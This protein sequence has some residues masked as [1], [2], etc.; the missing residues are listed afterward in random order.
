M[1]VRN[2]A[3]VIARCLESVRP[4]VGHWV[5]VDTGSTDATRELVRDLMVDVPG[6]LLRHEWIDFGHNRSLALAAARPHAE[7]TLMIDADEIFDVPDGF[8]WP[9]LTSDSVQLRHRAGNTVYWRK[10]MFANR[11]PWRYVGVLHEYPEADGE[12][13]SDRL[14]EPEVIGYYDGGRS[15]GLSNKE[16]Y[17]RDARVLEAAV[18]A[19]PDN[20]RYQYYLARSY[21][22]SGQ[23]QLA[24]AAFRRRAEMPGGFAEE[25]ADS[26]LEAAG[27]L[28]RSGTDF[29][30]VVTAY[31][32][33]WESRPIR[34]EALAG[35]ARYCREQGRYAL[36]RMFAA[37]SLTIPRPDDL[38]WIDE[39]VYDWR[40]LDELAVCST[41]TGHWVDAAAGCELLLAEGR[42]PKGERSRVRKNLKLAREHLDPALLPGG[43][44]RGEGKKHKKG[45]K[46]G[47]AADH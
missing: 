39:E 43:K 33:A 2:E 7:Y 10:T 44:K 9:Q 5:I 31:L 22:D 13:S 14:A 25:V 34:A 37:H 26:L 21:R 16:K 38:L 3:H 19:E 32:R 35:L 47:S 8:A 4:Y 15:K 1:I 40:R 6:F 24:E 42:L 12:Q 11:L 17:A 27:Y 28:A 29:D 20:T 41:W 45:R 46:P 36:G 23:D 30:A 18:A